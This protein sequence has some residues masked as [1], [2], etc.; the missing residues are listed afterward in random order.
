M[1]GTQTV[2]SFL[3]KY[4]APVRDTA[5]AARKLLKDALPDVTE[6]VDA[7][8]KMVAYTYGP[9]YKGFVCSLIVSKSG[10]K[11]GIFRGSELPDPKKLLAGA[12]KVHRHVQL[13]SPSDATQPALKALLKA[14][15]SA[16]KKRNAE[17]D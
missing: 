2:D 9:G 8:A 16:W 12:G 6:S 13:N 15:H 3:A 1:P 17:S 10:V 5:D 11:L 14:A 4:P 7:S